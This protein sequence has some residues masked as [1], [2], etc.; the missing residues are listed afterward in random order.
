MC[1]GVA[2][3]CVC[4]RGC[5]VCVCGHIIHMGE[6]YYVR[7]WHACGCCGVRV[8]M[9]EGVLCVSVSHVHVRAVVGVP[10]DVKRV[11]VCICVLCV[12]GV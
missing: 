5:V 12:H 2:R 1:E 9:G 8:C 7:G 4:G 11:Y 6:G 10:G 3:A